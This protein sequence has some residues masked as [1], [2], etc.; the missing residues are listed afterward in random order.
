MIVRLA[1]LVALLG[2]LVSPAAAVEASGTLLAQRACPALQSIK[3][4]TNPGNIRLEP[5]KGYE[6]LEA[7]RRDEPTHFRVLVPGAS[8]PQ[9]WVEISCG[10]AADAPTQPV[11]QPAEKPIRPG[12]YML[13]ASWQPGFCETQPDK[14]ECLDQP[15]SRFDASHFAL[16]GLWPQ[17]RGNEYCGVDAAT[18][19]ADTAS[20][21]RFLP[22]VSLTERTR[23]ELETVMPGTASFL[24]RHEWITHGTCSGG[25]M[26]SYF[27][28]SLELMRELN[29]SA[30]R[31]YLAGKIGQSLTPSQIRAAA[32]AAFGKGAG[33]RIR[34]QCKTE[35]DGYRVVLTELQIQL[36]GTFTG[37]VDLGELIRSAPRQ[38]S[39]ARQCPSVVIDR[40]GL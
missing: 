17:P 25:S 18:W 23:A 6:V 37:E 39:N 28:A 15:E 5:G 22:E 11:S 19:N 31:T 2:G 26:E 16:H 32:D 21:W 7:N 4:Q 13:A 9:R 20:G 12:T 24:D 3:Q 30:L 1:L 34:I 27:A 38:D 14:V 35:Q 10:S 8:P 40:A 36:S 33:Q 29:A